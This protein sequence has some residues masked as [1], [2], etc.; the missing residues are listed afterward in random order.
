MSSKIYIGKN[1]P[2]GVFHLS[3]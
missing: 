1:S 2:D 3:S